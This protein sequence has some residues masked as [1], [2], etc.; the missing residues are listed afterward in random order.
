M[1]AG[2]VQVVL[3]LMAGVGIA[4]GLV[5]YA[6][7][8]NSA[9]LV[10]VL[11]APAF[12]YLGFSGKLVEFGGLGL[13]AKFREAASKKVLPIK[14]ISTSPQEVEESGPRKA[15][16]SIGTEVV[17]L[18]ASDDNR[19][20]THEAV[21]QVAQ[22]IYPG[23]LQG[24]FELLVVLDKN[25]RVVGYFAKE[26]FHDLLRIEVEQ[27]IRGDRQSFDHAT[28]RRQL[29]QT[30]L[31]SIVAHPRVRAELDG[32]KLLLSTSDSNLEAL[33]K[34]SQQNQHAAVVAGPYAKYAGLVRRADIVSELVASLAAP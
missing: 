34:L 24:K 28:V 17:I 5:K 16:F 33:K 32:E 29:E 20:A 13:Q 31:W 18:R 10:A 15:F 1:D 2:I 21:L 22:K 9:V 12:L 26:F 23:L 7:L 11:F 25:D 4:V 8:D 19:A 30:E 27:V 14:P 3:A 6:K